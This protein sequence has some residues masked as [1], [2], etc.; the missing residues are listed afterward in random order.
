MSFIKIAFLA[1]ILAGCGMANASDVTRT[2][3]IG[4]TL[5]GADAGSVIFANPAQTF[6]QD[7]ANLYWSDSIQSLGIG[8]N[9]P[10]ANLDI[11]SAPSPGGSQMQLRS[12]SGADN[13]YG[14][15]LAISKDGR[16]LYL[17]AA[18]NSGATYYFTHP[19]NATIATTA[20]AA[21]YLN[22]NA[23]DNN[24]IYIGTNGAVGIGTTAPSERF[25]IVGKFQVDSNGDPVLINDVPYAWPGSQGGTSTYLENNGSGTLSWATIANPL[26]IGNPVTGGT[27][28]SVLF[29]NGSGDLAQDN[30]NLYWNDSSH[31]LGL[32]TNNPQDTI[33][34]AGTGNISLG[35]F[36]ALGA[37]NSVYFGLYG[38]GGAWGDNSGT[39]S[40][41][42]TQVD[43]S[44]SNEIG[45]RTQ[46]SGVSSTT[47]L[48]I[49]KD[50]NIGIDTTSPAYPLDVKG[51]FQVD[52]NG[53]P[54]KIRGVSYAWP[55]S[56]GG[57]TTYLV[58][59][60]SGNLSWGASGSSQWVT[61]GSNIYYTAG[62]VG[63]G[64]ASPQFKLDLGGS[65][66]I[67][68]AGLTTLGAGNYVNIGLSA[69]GW[70]D[71][72]GAG[73]VYFEQVDSGGSN[74]VGI[75]TQH[76]GVS[77]STRLY[78][79]KDGNVGID[80]VSPAAV[81]DVEG[82]NYKLGTAGTVMTAQGTCSVSASTISTTPSTVT[83]TGVPATTSVAVSCNATSAFSTPAAAALY[84]AA[85]GTANSISCNTTVINTNSVALYCMWMQ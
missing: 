13:S 76:S 29:V 36:T 85:T 34:L 57:A 35:S 41:Y 33:D 73:S 75:R 30:A 8:T 61:S 23:T 52:A 38:V 54:L 72:S 2:P 53:D 39:G 11:E 26:A 19:G 47:R 28:G 44:G 55:S 78:V 16:G 1:L 20:N 15:F 12:N 18:D 65:G 79:D 42:F 63:I 25:D 31:A 45:F 69:G 48:L 70:G 59:D 3:V 83:C 21:L 66:S 71:N 60:G 40:M 77:S 9:S 49:D 62:N 64:S 27:S 80:T 24:G 14:S 50:G 6:A 7:N 82:S 17:S 32:G 10:N 84:C 5:L 22:T 56:Q 68:M 74:A 51:A 37:G 4:G 58:N 43:S 46:H 67:G 81:L